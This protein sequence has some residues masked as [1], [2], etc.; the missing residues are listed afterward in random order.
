MKRAELS[1]FSLIIVEGPSRSGK[2]HLSLYLAG[3][4][5]EAEQFPFIIEGE[6]VAEWFRSSHSAKTLSSRDVLLIDDSDSYLMGLTEEQRGEFVT[7][8]EDYRQACATIVLLSSSDLNTL[9]SDG[10]VLSR[11]RAAEQYKIIGAAPDEAA[12]IIEHM[13]SQRGLKLSQKKVSYLV[14][15]LGRGMGEVE[16]YFDRLD[17]LS[18][19]LGSSIKFPLLSDAL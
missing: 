9:N 3:I 15:R 6:R 13:A 4:L 2:T 7:L 8:V 5:A 12:T 11:V 1:R 17:Y 10:H 19:V 14:K 18:R 16:D